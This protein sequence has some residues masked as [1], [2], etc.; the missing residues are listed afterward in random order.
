MC[1]SILSNDHETYQSFHQNKDMCWI[2]W[3]IFNKDFKN[4]FPFHHNIFPQ[5][6][7]HIK[8]YLCVCILVRTCFDEVYQHECFHQVAWQ[9]SRLMDRRKTREGGLG[10]ETSA[11]Y[12]SQWLHS[13][14][15]WAQDPCIKPEI[16]RRHSKTGC[17]HTVTAAPAAEFHT[18][19]GSSTAHC[20]ALMLI[21]T[22]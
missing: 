12:L 4:Y 20:P 14:R 11:F 18:Y 19:Q 6:F 22:R 17:A 10:R 16:S 7:Q 15:A 21:P 8:Y 5:W 3:M 9:L 1:I 13:R 2:V